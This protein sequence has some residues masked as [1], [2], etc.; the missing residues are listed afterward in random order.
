MR[1]DPVRNEN[2]VSPVIGTILMVAITVILAAVVAALVFSMPGNMQKTRLVTASVSQ[3][4]DDLR[5]IYHG[6]ID[7]G[8]LMYI[9]ITTPGNDAIGGDCIGTSDPWYPL[10][11][12]GGTTDNPLTLISSATVPAS[13]AK[14]NVG[15]VYTLEGCGNSARNHVVITGHFG[16]GTD[17]V[18]LDTFV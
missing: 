14:P 6:G 17:Q 2:A 16:E 13:P 7:D 5:V 12:A 1:V 8:P 11:E 10:A 18:I 4:A 15:A 9:V 3:E